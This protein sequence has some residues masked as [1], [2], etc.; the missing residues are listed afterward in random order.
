MFRTRL[1]RSLLIPAVLMVPLSTAAIA[2]STASPAGASVAS[3]PKDV[4]TCTKLTGK[5][6][7]ATESATGTFSGC[8]SAPTGGTGKFSGSESTSSGSVTWKNKGV[9]SM[10]FGFSLSG[11]ACGSNQ[12]I[13][14]TGTVSGSTGKASKIAAGQEISGGKTKNTA[15]FCWNSSNNDLTLAS[16]TKFEI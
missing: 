3:P 2:L 10:S 14:V 6:A 11:S 15:D 16:G 8:T 9:T 7:I 13:I 4:V 1:A 5:V 12:E